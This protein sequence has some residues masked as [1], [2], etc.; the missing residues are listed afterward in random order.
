MKPLMI[1]TSIWVDWLRGHKKDLR[2]EARGR[3][4]FLPATVAMELLS[5]AHTRKNY[6]IV[7]DLIESFERNNRFI[8][9]TIG[10]FKQAGSTLADLHWPASKKSNDVLIIVCARKIGAEVWTCDYADFQPI[11]ENLQVSLRGFNP[12][13]T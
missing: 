10:D 13:G 4:Q 5:G 1:D 6:K 9:P 12:M 8:L 2:E 11:A 3:V 7:S